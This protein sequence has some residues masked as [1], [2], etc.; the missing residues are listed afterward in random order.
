MGGLDDLLWGGFE[1]PIH[2]APSIRRLHRALILDF[3]AGLASL[4]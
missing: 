4:G 1:Q 3:C 2:S